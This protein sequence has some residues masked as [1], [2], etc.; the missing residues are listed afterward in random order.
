[1]WDD[2]RSSSPREY[3]HVSD[4]IVQRVRIILRVSEGTQAVPVK[5]ESIEESRKS[6][7]RNQRAITPAARLPLRL[8]LRLAKRYAPPSP[9]YSHDARIG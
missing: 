6:T 7:A 1:M 5:E 8:P 4:I 9:Q 2:V 3:W